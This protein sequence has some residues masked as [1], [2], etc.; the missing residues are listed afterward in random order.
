ML[1]TEGSQGFPAEDSVPLSLGRELAY[2][3]VFVIVVWT[4]LWNALISGSAGALHPGRIYA[5]VCV[6]VEI[7]LWRLWISRA[8]KDETWTRK[9]G[10][11][12]A[13]PGQTS[14]TW[15]ALDGSSLR[16]E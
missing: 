12:A 5:I 14:E 4:G 11:T 15:Q 9:D 10:D 13:V 3:A 6:G 2:A 7:A 8:G 1:H 16:P